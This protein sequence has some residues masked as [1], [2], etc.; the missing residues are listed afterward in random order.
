MVV[1]DLQGPMGELLGTGQV[2]R[3]GPTGRGRQVDLEHRCL[4]V[5]DRAIGDH[6]HRLGD[7]NTYPREVP[8]GWPEL[9]LVLDAGFV[10]NQDVDHCT[11]PTSNQNCP[12]WI[13]VTS[14]LDLSPVAVVV[15]RPDHRPITA[16]VFPG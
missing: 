11:M 8:P 3:S 13:F 16:A 1:G 10:T 4:A 15:D 2:G 7:M 6:G 12:D 5:E 9:D 14:D